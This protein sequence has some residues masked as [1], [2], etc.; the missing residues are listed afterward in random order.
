MALVGQLI[1][2]VV[3]LGTAFVMTV[4]AFLDVTVSNEARTRQRLTAWLR[5]SSAFQTGRRR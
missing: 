5:P 4:V 2:I 1:T 3:F